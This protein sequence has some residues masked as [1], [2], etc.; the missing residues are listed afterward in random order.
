MKVQLS[1]HMMTIYLESRKEE[2]AVVEWKAN[3][4]KRGLSSDPEG[5]DI[6]HMYTPEDGW[7]LEDLRTALGDPSDSEHI[8]RMLE[9]DNSP[10]ATY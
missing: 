4:R 6:R 1:Y 9:R 2:E 7:T 5:I 3:L 10:T 8:S